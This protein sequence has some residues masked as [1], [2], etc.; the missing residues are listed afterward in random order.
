MI[1]PTMNLRHILPALALSLL[2]PSSAAA[3]D[4]SLIDRLRFETR[5]ADRFELRL[6]LAS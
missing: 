5:N 1:R 3:G 6:G 4:G 2:V